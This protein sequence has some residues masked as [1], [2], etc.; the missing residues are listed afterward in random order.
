MF[1][2]NLCSMFRRLGL[3]GAYLVTDCHIIYSVKG[4]VSLREKKSIGYAAAVPV[5]ISCDQ[6][7]KYIIFKSF[8]LLN[9]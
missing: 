8:G 2:S 3:Q 7:I 5:Y 9:T 6:N 4:L 1:L